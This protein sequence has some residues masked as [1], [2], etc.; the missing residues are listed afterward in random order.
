LNQVE[1]YFSIVQR[2]VLSPNDVLSLEALAQR[3]L[4]FQ[5]YSPQSARNPDL[6]GGSRART[7]IVRLRLI[8]KVLKFARLHSANASAKIQF[9]CKDELAIRF[10][11]HT[12][13]GV[14]IAR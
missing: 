6:V 14:D 10:R 12:R 7:S 2:K 9:G 8:R 11:R 1:I 3:L 13:R 4:D 5:F